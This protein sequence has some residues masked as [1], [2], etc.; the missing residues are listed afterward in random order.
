MEILT[1]IVSV[2]H[3][4][5][6]S[7]PPQPHNGRDVLKLGLREAVQHERAAQEVEVYLALHPGA[8]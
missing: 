8:V 6:A 1:R 4:R 3:G 7:V 5:I 2:A